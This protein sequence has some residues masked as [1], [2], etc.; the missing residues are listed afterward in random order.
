MTFLGKSKTFESIKV[1]RDFDK[2][3]H[4]TFLSN[5][6]DLVPNKFGI[7]RLYVMFNPSAYKIRQSIWMIVNPE[8]SQQSPKVRK[9]SNKELQLILYTVYSMYI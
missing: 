7:A 3:D 5:R 1:R 6:F 4:H 2:S 9:F 8:L